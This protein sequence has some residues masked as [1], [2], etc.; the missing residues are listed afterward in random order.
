MTRRL[1]TL[2]LAAALTACG[3][4]ATA[5]PENRDPFARI[6]ADRITI[7]EGD[8]LT[9]TVT[10]SGLLSSGTESWDSVTSTKP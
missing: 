9:T 8:E 2:V 5:T 4:S 7:K 3:D 6:N 10:L 1:M